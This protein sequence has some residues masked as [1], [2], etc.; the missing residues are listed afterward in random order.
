MGWTNAHQLDGTVGGFTHRMVGGRIKQ[1]KQQEV[2]KQTT[3]NML[4]GWQNV[5]DKDQYMS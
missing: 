4:V 3:K 2:N 5:V 1:V